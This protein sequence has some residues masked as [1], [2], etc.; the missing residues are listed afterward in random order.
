MPM[1]VYPL[2]RKTFLMLI[3]TVL[4]VGVA[5]FL[6]CINIFLFNEWDWRQPAI[7]VAWAVSSIA[8]CILTP[9]NVYYEVNKKYVLVVKYRKKTLYNF[10]DVVYIDEEKS[11]K[12]KSVHFFTNKGHVR[13]LTFDRKDVLYPTMLAHCKNRISKEEFIENYPKVK[14]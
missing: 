11:V 13:Y 10:A 5:L 6:M 8:L 9:L 1:K 4:F 12:H 3:V 2:F 7:I 14:L